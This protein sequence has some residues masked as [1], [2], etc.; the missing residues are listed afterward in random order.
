MLHMRC[1]APEKVPGAYSDDY[2]SRFW[3]GYGCWGL[4]ALVQACWDD[5]VHGG[6][7]S[8]HKYFLKFCI[9][10]RVGLVFPPCLVH[11]QSFLWLQPTGGHARSL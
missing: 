8:L 3:P 10:L 11:A 6:L 7:L 9:L 4:P 1:V 5:P 2:R